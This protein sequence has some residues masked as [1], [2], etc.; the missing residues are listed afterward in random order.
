[1]N[2]NQFHIV[3]RFAK[4]WEKTVRVRPGHFKAG[5]VPI[6]KVPVT[7]R[8]EPCPCQSGLKYKKCHG[9]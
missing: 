9:A 5:T 8:N 1:M 2:N 7:G 3:G 4:P 6:V